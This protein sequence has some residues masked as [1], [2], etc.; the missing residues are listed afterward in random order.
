MA[1]PPR[2]ETPLQI[3]HII[4]KLKRR[5]SFGRILLEARSRG[6]L[7][8]HRTLRR[9]LDLL[10]QAKVL[11]VT[12]HDVG[13]VHPQQLYTQTSP[14]AHL[15]T[16]PGA[17]TVQ[18]LNWT[19]SDNELYPVVTDLEAMVRAKPHQIAGK[20][21]LVASL[22]DTLIYELQRDAAEKTGLTELIASI[23]ATQTL[24]LAYLLRRA[25]SEQVGQTLRHLFRKTMETF[26]SLPGNSEGRTFLEA[27]TRF[28]RV[29]QDYKYKG[30]LR[31]VETPGRGQNGL[32]IV[33]GLTPEQLVI[34]TGKQLGITG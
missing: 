20:E 34:A 2:P 19:I 23:L 14:R 33:K 7:A 30:L 6:F 21:K 13:S 18:G 4:K 24:D 31:L 26:T 22:E 16:G 17:L 5:A 8:W 29:L 15:W 1:P 10:V 27:R 3:L 11:K 12:Q 28:L 9:Y 25:D 32:R